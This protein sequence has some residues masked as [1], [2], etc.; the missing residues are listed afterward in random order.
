MIQPPTPFHLRPLNL[1]DLPALA[2]IEGQ[3]FP[4]PTREKVFR[5]ELTENRLA[6]YQAL[7]LENHEQT[8]RLLG[9]TGFWL[10]ADEVHIST[11]AVDPQWRGHNLG[12]LLL[13]NLL[14]LAYDHDAGLVT[15]EVRI[16]NLTAQSLYRKYRFE[17]VGRR[18][19][20]Y[21]D[22]GEDAI[23]MTVQLH[24]NPSY[25][26][27]LQEKKETLFSRLASAQL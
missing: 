12:E 26:L 25:R 4:T 14:F 22:T 9:Y 13:L 15:L 17:E 2:V 3:S 1:S 5:Y 6:H 20:Y 21:R 11:I 23:L 16:N 27:F 10:I 24:S 19:R 8:E 7:L 18:R